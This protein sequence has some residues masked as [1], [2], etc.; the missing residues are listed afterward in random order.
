MNALETGL[1]DFFN[2]VNYLKWLVE[3][4][5]RRSSWDVKVLGFQ[6]IKSVS[7]AHITNRILALTESPP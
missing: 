4:M 5:I 1:S 2:N 3:P 7:S 6:F